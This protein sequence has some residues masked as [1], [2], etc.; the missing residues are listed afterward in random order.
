[1]LLNLSGYDSI[2]QHTTVFVKK[3]WKSHLSSVLSRLNR[4]PASWPRGPASEPCYCPQQTLP[5]HQKIAI[6]RSR[7]SLTSFQAVKA[8]FFF[9]FWQ[10]GSVLRAGWLTSRF[11]RRAPGSIAISFSSVGGAD[12]NGPQVFGPPPLHHLAPSAPAPLSSVHPQR[13]RKNQ[14]SADKTHAHAHQIKPCDWSQALRLSP[15]GATTSQ[16]SASHIVVYHV[17]SVPGCR[18]CCNVG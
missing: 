17:C 2:T 1:M 13:S 8:F 14:D 3:A 18:V 11:G 5:Y 12:K 4:G 15:P 9:F 7:V 10:S 6:H 16:F